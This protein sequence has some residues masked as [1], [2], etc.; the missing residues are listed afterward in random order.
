MNCIYMSTALQYWGS[1]LSDLMDVRMYQADRV[2]QEQVQDE[3]I[4]RFLNR[5]RQYGMAKHVDLS[6]PED[7]DT[8]LRAVA[9]F[10]DGTYLLALLRTEKIPDADAKDIVFDQ[11]PQEECI[12]HYGIDLSRG[13]NFI[14]DAEYTSE[15]YYEYLERFLTGKE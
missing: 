4:H 3:F 12:P 8:I 11:W 10:R 15:N 13:C 6:V 9:R 2:G 5:A 7:P 14:T 1:V